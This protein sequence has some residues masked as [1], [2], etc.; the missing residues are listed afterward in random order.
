[1]RMTKKMTITLEEELINEVAKLAQSTGKKKTQII[2][3]ALKEYLPQTTQTLEQQWKQ[4]N[5]QAFVSYN[6]RLNAS[7]IFSDNL[8]SF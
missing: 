8:R 6:K 7:G 2:R 1:M 5:A 4:D 3:E